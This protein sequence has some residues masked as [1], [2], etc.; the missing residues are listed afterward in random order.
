LSYDVNEKKF[1]CSNCKRVYQN[2]Y[3]GWNAIN[4]RIKTNHLA[5]HEHT[6]LH[7]KTTFSIQTTQLKPTI[8]FEKKENKYIN[9]STLQL[10]KN[11]V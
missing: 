6:H 11:I 9:D 5:I 10:F 7:Q 8:L 4:G 1:I 2:H 3:S